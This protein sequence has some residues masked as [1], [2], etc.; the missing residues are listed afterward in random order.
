M[1]TH[2]SEAARKAD[3]RRRMAAMRLVRVDGH[4]NTYVT[5]EQA[6]LV[7]AYV[8]KIREERG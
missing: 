3:Y 8:A 5:P 7:A 1:T 4:C 6:A 2:A